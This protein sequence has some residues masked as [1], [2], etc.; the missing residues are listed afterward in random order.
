MT[1]DQFLELPAAEAKNYVLGRSQNESARLSALYLERHGVDFWGYGEK[2]IED[3]VV[4]PGTV[5]TGGWWLLGLGLVGAAVAFF[6]P[7]G[8]D[9]VGLYGAPDQ[10]AN[11][12]KIAI[13]H[14]ILAVSLAS[15][16]AGSVLIGAGA[17]QRELRRRK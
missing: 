6:Y 12:D 9:T 10:V 4:E 16:V 15:F 2:A 1:D 17:L 7:V 8:V 11:L 14:M 13:R 3:A 5:S